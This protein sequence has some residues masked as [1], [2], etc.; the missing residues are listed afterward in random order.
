MT[1]RKHFCYCLSKKILH[2][3]VAFEMFFIAAKQPLQSMGTRPCFKGKTKAMLL[4][5]FPADDLITS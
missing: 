4:S 3:V 2:Y 5:V 1:R